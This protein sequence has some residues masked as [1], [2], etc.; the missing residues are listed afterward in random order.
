MLKKYVACETGGKRGT[1][2]TRWEAHLVTA[3]P[4]RLSRVSQFD[5][6]TV[7]SHAEGRCHGLWLRW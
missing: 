3:R 7:Q 6:R 5:S 2:K 4:S 1:G